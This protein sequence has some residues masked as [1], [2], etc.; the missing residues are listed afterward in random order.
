[1]EEIESESGLK[2]EVPWGVCSLQRDPKRKGVLSPQAPCPGLPGA[3]SYHSPEQNSPN[4]QRE[5]GLRHRSPMFCPDSTSV[6]V[7]R[8]EGQPGSEGLSPWDGSE[9]GVAGSQVRILP[10]SGFSSVGSPELPKGVPGRL[11]V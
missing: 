5:G 4:G 9:I 6:R 3:P 1:M 10:Q 8:A 2:E 7:R 11:K